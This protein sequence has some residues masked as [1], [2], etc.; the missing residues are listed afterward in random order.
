M[1]MYSVLFVKIP[2]MYLRNCQIYCKI[3]YYVLQFFSLWI[4]FSPY[5][6]LLQ[7]SVLIFCEFSILY[8]LFA[9]N[10]SQHFQSG[11][12]N[13]L[14]CIAVFQVCIA[15]FPII[16]CEFPYISSKFLH[17]VLWHSLLCI[18]ILAFMHCKIYYCICW[19]SLLLLCISILLCIANF[20]IMHGEFPYYVL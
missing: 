3:Q 14:L 6:S 19:I 9:L 15:N 18:A 20:S 5:Y 2:I 16:Y 12:A 10:R 7:I 13:F 8:C 17:C 1:Q 11:F 4:S